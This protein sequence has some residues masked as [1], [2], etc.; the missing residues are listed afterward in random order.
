MYDACIRQVDDN[1]ARLV[2]FLEETGSRDQTVLM[3]TSDHGEAFWEHGFGSHGRN[4]YDEEIRVPLIL[5]NPVRYPGAQTIEDQVSLIDLVPTI[6]DLAGAPDSQ[7]RE[8]RNLNDLV[9]HGRAERGE[10]GLLP[11]DLELS[12]STLRKAPDTKG[13]RSNDWKLIIE[14]ATS[15]VQLYNLRDDPLETVNVWGKGG[16]LGDSLLGLLQRVPGSSVDGWRL[17]FVKGDTDAGFSAT[18]RLSAGQRFVT[19]ERLV[20]GG[21]FEL[22]IPADSASFHV[23]VSPKGQQIILF[24]AEPEDAAITF[25]IEVEGEGISDLISAGSAGTYSAGDMFTLTRD[26]ALGLPEAFDE[27]RRTKTA[28]A[29]LWWLPGRSTMEAGET[30]RLSPEERQRL[31]ALGY[32]Q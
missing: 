7:H 9:D 12:E 25:K 28:G 4:V 13:I 23:E 20:S 10:G 2:S 15:L 8:G 6:V 22:E 3:I 5:N 14:P 19:V 31:K 21:D 18:A 16:A 32:I 30:T 17:G 24:T 1:V 11:S 29:C 27:E 26:E